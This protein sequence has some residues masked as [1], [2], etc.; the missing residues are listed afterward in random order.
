MKIFTL[1]TV[2]KRNRQENFSDIP[3]TY[4]LSYLGNKYLSQLRLVLYNSKLTQ[5]FLFMFLKFITVLLAHPNSEL[6]IILINNMYSSEYSAFSVFFNI[7]LCM[8]TYLSV[9]VCICSCVCVCLC[10]CLLEYVYVSV[11]YC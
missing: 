2:N 3:N 8:S 5:I 1:V 11:C 4:T 7:F 9:L 6:Y 10:M